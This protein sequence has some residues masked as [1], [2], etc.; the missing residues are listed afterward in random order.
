MS[1]SIGELFREGVVLVKGYPGT[2]KT[3][4]V[5]K[6]VSQYNNVAWFTFYETEDRL[7]KYL[8]SAGVRSPAH[9]FGIVSTSPDEAVNFIV[10][11]VLE[12]KPDAVVVDGVS[13]LTA[14][15]E[16][17]CPRGLLPRHF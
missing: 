9:I 14:A 17:T 10:E 4:L 5:A 11:K 12:V 1:C 13:A 15:G 8:T 7:R 2:G 3:L 16:R 6:A